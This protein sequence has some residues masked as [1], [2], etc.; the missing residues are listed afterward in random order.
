VTLC[1][2]LSIVWGSVIVSQESLTTSGYIILYKPSLR[3]V[4]GYVHNVF[5]LLRCIRDVDVGSCIGDRN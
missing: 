3:I 4:V 1:L 5:V 2:L